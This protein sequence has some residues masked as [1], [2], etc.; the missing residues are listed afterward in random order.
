VR[1]LRE[2]D[3]R[4]RLVR[5]R[6]DFGKSAALNA[7]FRAARGEVVV[8][9][10]ADG[11]DDPAELPKLLAEL[12]GGADVVTGRKARRQDP[13]S[14]TL[15]S[16]LFN[17]MVSLLTGVQ[18]RDINSGFKVYRRAVTAELALYG[19]LYRFVPVLAHARG[20][21][22]AEV[23][24]THRPRRHGR[25]KFGVERLARGLFDLVTVLFLTRWSIRPL[26]LFG[27]VGAACLLLGGAVSAWF[28]AQWLSGVPMH[29][30]PIMIFGWILIVL[31]IQFVSMGLLADMM[32][33]A[34][35]GRD[36][37]PPPAEVDP[38]VQER[39][40]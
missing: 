28:M 35:R 10:D 25:S 22:V 12:D 21:R 24:V 16:R 2:A 8:T 5:L 29:V 32:L 13:A 34:T 14:K 11:Q 7:G 31:G 1:A 6:R 4:V 3:G 30:R 26:H 9:M 15:P 40:G 27:V 23:P 18:V 33:A 36:A 39:A 37:D 38:P 17:R 20:F 19:E